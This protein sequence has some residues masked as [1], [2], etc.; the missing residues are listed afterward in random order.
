MQVP[1]NVTTTMTY[2]QVEITFHNFNFVVY[3]TVAIVH[4]QK[5]KHI[6]NLIFLNMKNIKLNLH[7]DVYT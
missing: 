1:V 4:T 7:N 3:E 6:G 2:K 5:N